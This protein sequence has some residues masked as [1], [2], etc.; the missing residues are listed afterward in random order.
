MTSG[1]PLHSGE[2]DHWGESSGGEP[3]G[4]TT[5]STVSKYRG[6]GG[7]GED[8]RRTGRKRGRGKIREVVERDVWRCG[9]IYCK[10][11]KRGR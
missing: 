7:G 3:A 1:S 5:N 8:V 9:Q 10:L 2:S 6:G 4:R 11:E